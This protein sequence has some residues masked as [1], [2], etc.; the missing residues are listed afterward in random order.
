MDERQYIQED[1]I[2]L[3]ELILKI[4]EYTREV[5]RNWWVVALITIPFVAYFLYKAYTTPVTYPATLT[6]M[7]N[8][9]EGGSLGG[10]SSILSQFGFG[11]GG[12]SEYNLDKIV[13]LSR[14]KRIIGEVLMAKGTVNGQEDYYANHIIRIHELHK[15]WKKETTGLKTFFFT[16]DSI[17]TFSRLENR[18][19]S[20]VIGIAK[21]NPATKVVGIMSSG[22]DETSGILNFKI[23]SRSEDL[24]IG[25]ANEFYDKI[26]HFYVDKSIEKQQATYEIV[27]SKVDSLQIALNAKQRAYL[28]FE[29]SHRGLT[30][31]RYEARKLEMERDLQVLAMAYGESVKNLE[32]ADFSLKSATPFFQVVD[33]PV[34]PLKG[35]RKSKVKELLLAFIIGSAVSIL[36]ILGRYILLELLR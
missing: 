36:I 19:L 30:L 16:H 29:D 7:V 32:I 26:S 31:K 25:L 6:Y 12:N 22:Y 33:E 9:D 14:S 28:N 27:Q 17:S 4:Q 8:E 24:S 15:K 35:N 11:G 23:D 2:T 13:Q 20:G 34:G 21:G 1:E 10:V 18:A 5:I 3:K